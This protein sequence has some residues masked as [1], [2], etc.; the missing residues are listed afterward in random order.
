MTAVSPSLGDKYGGARLTLTVSVPSGTITGVSI[1]GTA[2][3]NVVQ[4][5]PT[6]VT[7]LAPAKDPGVYDVTVSNG[8]TSAPLV[9]AYESWH[10]TVDYP[11]A[12]VYQSDQGTTSASSA[13]RHRFGTRSY[14]TMAGAKYGAYR[15]GPDPA[16]NTFIAAGS[17]LATDGQGFVE[18]PSGRFILAGGAPA[19]HAYQVVNT[20]WA[21]D[22]R[23]KTWSVLLADGP[24]SSTRPAPAHAFGF[25]RMT[26]GGVDYVYWLGSDSFTPSGDVFRIPCSDL[27][28]GGNP[29][30]WTRISTTA[31]ALVLFLYGVLD[32]VIYVGAGQTDINDVGVPYKTWHKSTDG[33]VTWTSMG[34]IVPSNVYGG[35]LGPLPVKDGKLWIAG[36]GRYHSSINDFSN[37]VVTFDGTSFA[38][39]LADGNGQ[40]PKARYHSVVAF[41]GRLWRFN[42]STWNGTTFVS[43]TKTAHY[44]SDGATWTAYT[45]DMPWNQTHAQA[46][47]ASSDGIYLTDGFQSP[48]VFVIREHTGALVSAWTDLGSAAKNLSQATDAKKP[49]KDLTGFASQPGLVFTRGQLMTLASPDRGITGGVYEAYVVGRSSSFDTTPE[50]GVN[51]TSVA[52]GAINSSSWNNFGTFQINYGVSGA[53]NASPIV[54][55]TSAAHGLRTGDK[56][57]IFAVLGNTAANGTWIV[58]VLSSTTFSL[59]GSTGNAAYTTSGVVVVQHLCYRFF[60]P[61]STSMVRGAAYDDNQTHVLGV[62]HSAG[63]V[64]LYL[65]AV[66]QGADGSGTFDTTWIGWDSVGAGYLEGDK[67]ELIAGAVVVMPSAAATP[68]SFRTKLQTWSQKWA[69]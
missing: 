55:T 47:I 21:S 18:L 52:V 13:T 9:G 60:G 3:T 11:A 67:G 51:P 53:T 57:D 36:S 44:S 37:A 33:G 20:I 30:N 25:F 1:G 35:Q 2:C 19:G 22:D 64:R 7:C 65:D 46:A 49:I 6:T 4:T 34:A 66:Q 62:R 39:V 42:G 48:R 41:N 5:S 15:P 40:I 63:V 28:A 58:T 68:D 14:D 8:A 45:D 54:V 38:T 29:A 69:A 61:T 50:Q 56:V 10:P 27:E 31:P 26:Y 24:A 32:G 17:N 12:R 23:G 43:D 59:N 16:P